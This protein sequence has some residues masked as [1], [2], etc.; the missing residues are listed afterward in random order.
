MKLQF[1]NP[2]RGCWVFY[3]Q[4]Q[5]DANWFVSELVHCLLQAAT[6][7]LPRKSF[8]EYTKPYWNTEIKKLHK[9]ERKA[10]IEGIKG[11]RPRGYENVLYANYK[12]AKDL[13]RSAQRKASEEHI[14]DSMKEMENAAECNLRLF[15]QLVKKKKSK[16]ND[17]CIEIMINDQVLA[18][19]DLVLG[20]FENFYKEVYT[21]KNDYQFN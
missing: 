13:F 7:S 10:R 11:D 1:R 16:P 4:S 2:L 3:I 20:A 14:N 19:P 9:L 18:S 5:S 17:I 15:W 12:R 8:K 6:N 21:P